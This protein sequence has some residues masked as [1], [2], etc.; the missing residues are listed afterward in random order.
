MNKTIGIIAVK[1][2]VGKTT[3]VANLA[4]TLSKD[5]NKKVL[6]VDTNYSAPNLG[7]HLG[8]IDPVHSLHDVLQ[9]KVDIKEAI[10]S[11]KLGFDVLPSSLQSKKINPYKL[12]NRLDKV[13]ADYDVILLDS[14]PT[15]NEEMLSSIIASDEI[16]VVTSPDFPALSCALSSIKA[17]KNTTITGMVIN[18]SLGKG[19]EISAAEIEAT[20]G[21]PVLASLPHDVKSLE[22]LAKQVPL[23]FHKPKRRLSRHYKKLAAD[24]IGEEVPQVKLFSF[25]TRPKNKFKKTK[26]EEHSVVIPEGLKDL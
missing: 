6:A 12:K 15:Q 13:K 4:T 11:H 9:D 16:I 3:T 22:A 23:S 17:S 14:S 25:L 10:I 24:L 26:E 20:T 7:L 5:F 8:I 2:G 18:K 21:V 1:G 19:F